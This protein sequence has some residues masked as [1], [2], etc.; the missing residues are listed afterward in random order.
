MEILEAL[1]KALEAMKAWTDE[2][3]VSKVSGKDLSTNDY[4]TADK[5]KVAAMPND[6][7]I[8]NGKLYLA[9]DGVPIQDS[10]VELPSGGTVINGSGV[11]KEY[12]DNIVA[13]KTQVQIITWGADD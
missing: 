8:I 7:V 6:L 5:N 2:N 11:T 10:M 3:K 4:T 9:K 12:V 1:K 13:Q